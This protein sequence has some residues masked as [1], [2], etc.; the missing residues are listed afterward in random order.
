MTNTNCLEGVKCPACGN[1]D[2]FRIA[3]TTIAAVTDDGAEVEHGDMDWNPTSYAECASCHEYGTLARFM[4][5][6]TPAEGGMPGTN[7]TDVH[8]RAF[9]ALTSGRFDNFAL[10][11][12]FVNG[13][14]T[15]AIAAITRDGDSFD[16]TPLFV[17]VTGDMRLTDHDGR[18]A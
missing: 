18:P 14:P 6:R 11:S 2:T 10:F 15:A 9:N 12:C 13:S 1:E 4:A 8:R 3:V 5:P 17:A 16:I 7:I